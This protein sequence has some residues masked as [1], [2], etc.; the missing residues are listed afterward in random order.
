[1][2]M[3]D[4]VGTETLDINGA[5]IEVF[6]VAFAYPTDLRQ[7]KHGNAAI[8]RRSG[9]VTTSPSIACSTRRWRGWSLPCPRRKLRCAQREGCLGAERL[10]TKSPR[11]S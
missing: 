5:A 3:P 2:S 9:R 8:V 6:Y 11:T 4:G 7:L 10:P 1:M